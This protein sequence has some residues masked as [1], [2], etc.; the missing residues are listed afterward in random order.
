MMRFVPYL[1]ALLLFSGCAQIFDGNAFKAVD[2]PPTLSASTIKAESDSTLVTQITSDS[3]FITS[4][5]SNPDALS[6]VQGVLSNVYSNYPANG[7]SATTVVTDA[8]AYITA[9]SGATAA[10]TVVTSALSQAQTLVN[11]PSASSAATALTNMF[12]GQT[13]DQIVATL[14]QFENMS[15]AFSAMQTAATSGNTVNST[16]FYG[17]TSSK[18]NLAVTAA[19][20]ASVNAFVADYGGGSSA[21]ATLA[22]QLAKG[23]TPTPGNNV[24]A[25][26]AA[27]SGTGSDPNT[28]NYAY[29]ATVKSLVKT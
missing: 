3:S 6:A 1:P 24:N 14:T 20:A 18:L 26:A 5:K 28:N 22:G 7:V 23:N 21:I 8:Q 15:G 27:L 13:A 17:S 9:T 4:L 29:L 11:N 19:L 2:T 12:A 16:T 25:V 10:G